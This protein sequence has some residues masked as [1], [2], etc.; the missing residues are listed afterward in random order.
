MKTEQC[1]SDEIEY[2][3]I[4]GRECDVVHN[5]K[6]YTKEKEIQNIVNVLESYGE[7]IVDEVIK[8]IYENRRLKCKN[9]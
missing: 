3:D 5:I 7:K 8:K 6:I 1:D 4:C 9:V 2:C